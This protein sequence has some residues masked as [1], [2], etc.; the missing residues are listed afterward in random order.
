MSSL[1]RRRFL[2]KAS[3]GATAIAASMSAGAVGNLQASQVNS[4][5]RLNETAGIESRAFVPNRIAVSTYSFFTFRD[6]SKLTMPECI[7]T[8]AKMGFDGVELLLVQMEDTSDSMLQK[9][10]RR[11]FVN[12]LDLCGMSTHQ[13]FLR[14]DKNYRAENVK[15]TIAQIEMAYKLGIPT[16]RVN[17][18]RWGTSKSF[19]ELMNNKG[20]EPR[21]P[22]CTDDQGFQWVID[23]L[24]ECL[25]AAE[26]CGVVLGLENHW[27]LGSTAE[28]VLRIVNAINSP[29]LRV[30]MDTGNFFERR[31]EQLEMLAPEA[32]F[33]Q[34][35]T[36]F[37]GGVYYTLDMDYDRIAK[38]CQ[39]ANYKGYVSLEFEGK[40]DPW[41][42]VPKSLE[43]LRSAFGKKQS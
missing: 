16:I 17:T 1:N 10:K 13:G 7:D 41:T 31:Y 19:E 38:I 20:V 37:G 43:A 25:P 30:T 40:E 27:G 12:G 3:A 24:T 23:A 42:A 39:S 5:A 22:G 28:G 33:I 2:S 36:Y 26:K 32:V 8:A 21:L 14:P 11:A 35:K 9:L 34:A 15:K 4:T 18:G 29:W 6:G